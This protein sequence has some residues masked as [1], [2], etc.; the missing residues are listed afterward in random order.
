MASAKALLAALSSVN[1][2][3]HFGVDKKT[4][5]NTCG[6]VLIKCGP[7]DQDD[8]VADLTNVSA[9]KDEHLSTHP[10]NKADVD[11]RNLKRK[12]YD[13]ESIS[14][15]MD[16]DYDN[17]CSVEQILLNLSMEN[18]STLNEG[19]KR[20]TYDMNTVSIAL[21]SSRKNSI[22]ENSSATLNDESKEV[23]EKIK[24][25][26]YDLTDINSSTDKN[27]C[28][29]DVSLE[30]KRG[31]YDLTHVSDLI[32]KQCSSGKLVNE[33]SEIFSRSNKRKTYDILESNFILP[34][35][36]LLVNNNDN[37]NDK[38]KLPMAAEKKIVIAAKDPITN[39]SLC[40]NAN[41]LDNHIDEVFKQN[42]SQSHVTEV[43]CSKHK[44]S[45]DLYMNPDS[46]DDH[47]Q[48]NMTLKNKDS[49][50]PM[51]SAWPTESPL[52]LAVSSEHCREPSASEMALSKFQSQ[53]FLSASTSKFQLR[54]MSDSKVQTQFTSSSSPDLF[55]TTP[56]SDEIS[57]TGSLNDISPGIRNYL[58]NRLGLSVEQCIAVSKKLNNDLQSTSNQSKSSN[59]KTYSLDDVAQ[60]L[61][62]ATSQGLSMTEVLGNL[63]NDSS[64]AI[65]DSSGAIN[66]MEKLNE[67]LNVKKFDEKI[68]KS[69]A[70]SAS[71][72][73]KLAFDADGFVQSK[74]VNSHFV[75]K[76]F[77]LVKK[78]PV[79]KPSA[80][81]QSF[82]HLLGGKG[83][84]GTQNMRCG[85]LD[86]SKRNTYTLDSV[87]ECLEK[88]QEEGVP[89]MDALKRL[90]GSCKDDSSHRTDEKRRTYNLQDVSNTLETASDEGVPI[91]VTLRK[92]ANKSKVDDREERFTDSGSK[93]ENLSNV[94]KPKAKKKAP[95]KPKRTFACKTKSETN[96]VS[97]SFV[98]EYYTSPNK[99]NGSSTEADV[100]EN[101]VNFEVPNDEQTRQTS[102]E[103][104]CAPPGGVL[105]S[106][107]QNCYVN[108]ENVGKDDVCISQT[109]Q[110]MVDEMHLTSFNKT[111]KTSTKDECTP[112]KVVYDL[113]SL[114]SKLA[115]E[116]HKPTIIGSK[117]T[118]EDK[119]ESNDVDHE[120]LDGTLNMEIE[121]PCTKTDYLTTKGEF[122]AKSS[123]FFNMK[124]DTAM[125]K[126]TLF[127]KSDSRS[128]NESSKTKAEDEGYCSLS[129]NP[130]SYLE[131]IA[132]DNKDKVMAEEKSINQELIEIVREVNEDGRESQEVTIVMT[133]EDDEHITCNEVREKKEFQRDAVQKTDAV[134]RE[135]NLLR[136]RLAEKQRD[137][138]AQKQRTM[139][140]LEEERKKVGQN[141]FW[142]AVGKNRERTKDGN[143]KS[144]SS[145]Q[146]SSKLLSVNDELPPSMDKLQ[147]R[148]Y[149]FKIESSKQM[150]SQTDERKAL[151][152][153]Y[154][155][156]LL[157]DGETLWNQQK[158]HGTFDSS[159]D[160]QA[161][162]PPRKCWHAKTAG[163]DEP[164]LTIVQ[165]DFH[166]EKENT[167]NFN[168]ADPQNSDVLREIESINDS[169][170]KAKASQEIIPS[171]QSDT[172]DL[173][174]S[175]DLENENVLLSS[176]ECDSD[177]LKKG[178]TLFIGEENTI[179]SSN[180]FT[181]EQLR[182]KEKFLRNRQLKMEE[183][184]LRREALLEKKRRKEEKMKEIQERRELE[185]QSRQAKLQEKREQ[186]EHA[187]H[188]RQKY[189]M[190][191]KENLTNVHRTAGGN[192]GYTRKVQ[193]IDQLVSGYNQNEM[194][195]P[196]YNGGYSQYYK[197][198]IRTTSVESGINKQELSTSSTSSAFSG[199]TGVQ[200]YVKPSGKTN[201]KLIINAISHVC[202]PGTVNKD[203]KEKCLQ[204]MTE[205]SAQHFLI[206][207]KD[208]LKF[209]SLFS[210]DVESGQVLK[211]Y[212]IGPRSVS[213][214]MIE[215]LYKYN[216]GCKEFSKIPAKTFSLSVDGFTIQ[217]SFWQTSKP[218]VASKTAS[219]FKQSSYKSTR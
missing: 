213:E 40:H 23:N 88:A 143:E 13:L 73:E 155:N 132:L 218:S 38:E 135:L 33:C 196:G 137:I 16:D 189:E 147:D 117:S 81:L 205:S 169:N 97:D 19:N 200:S 120:R 177:Q 119:L 100:L 129:R 217:K 108:L 90:S 194:D 208:G 197:P 125:E 128:Q 62:I 35:G 22:L 116:V 24:R 111:F 46:D 168:L 43:I 85:K 31:T 206:L 209:R 203:T 148:S 219:N 82:T 212:G 57:R 211:V 30:S 105:G 7:Y 2:S 44:K 102:L 104:S 106:S 56:H 124:W 86:A 14:T 84:D 184:K 112:R 202:L 162:S 99:E 158:L 152:N 80:K 18:D 178:M 183:D 47:Q 96:F 176:G 11:D 87:A 114:L 156:N 5:E 163:I 166:V 37:F 70:S 66:D 101:V 77:K 149:E 173:A 170:D 133:A 142:L 159:S 53:S 21:D 118:T 67:T 76:P 161:I 191:R 192:K 93:K 165:P 60:S 79:Y 126:N 74:C 171:P 64:G 181:P 210:L 188:E 172:G 122:F 103:N 198:M 55:V 12:T 214:K 127:T 190:R 51:H 215:Y 199:F 207:F 175:P 48:K 140:Q 61:D 17:D 154:N 71:T 182:K 34:D 138:V 65:N 195:T 204:A 91:S 69:V 72:S 153:T 59:R 8:D 6:S 123:D 20:L 36:S 145:K 1:E 201:R 95:P 58:T 141:V 29:Y 134:S 179:S 42:R 121:L 139:E 83:V 186:A 136:L 10:G 26:T 94:R 92:I 187:K 160:K 15:K 25:H 27:I 115:A 109:G 150:K 185:E 78:K 49:I 3:K 9:I 28:V 193:G 130:G 89:M 144:L 174:S 98:I 63:D 180:G 45:H 52:K 68:L 157:N 39:S 110:I 167:S 32:D 164:Y 151:S 54:S 216:S 75:E 107:M 146:S 131:G 50:S 41:L 113:D 4:S